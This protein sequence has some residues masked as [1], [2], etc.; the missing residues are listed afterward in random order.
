M[1]PVT[2]PDA[3]SDPLDP[4]VHLG[5]QAAESALRPGKLAEFGV[6]AFRPYEVIPVRPL[7]QL[8]W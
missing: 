1:N 6:T 2:R 5:E 7:P 4:Y 8:P 3:E